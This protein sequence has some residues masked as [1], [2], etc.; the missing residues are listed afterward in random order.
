MQLSRLAVSAL[1][2]LAAVAVAPTVAH[3]DEPPAHALPE[4][5][6]DV[7]TITSGATTSGAGSTMPYETYELS[8][9]PDGSGGGGHPQADEACAR[10][11]ALAA[12]G[13]DPFAPVPADAMC[14]MQYGGPETARITGTWRGQ[15]VTADFDRRN[16]CEIGRWNQLVPVLPEASPDSGGPRVW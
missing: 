5:Q 11:D 3:A 13:R 14:T 15:Q 12:E 10:L 1:A 16:G 6:P 8:C 9:L 2:A 7:L 4:P